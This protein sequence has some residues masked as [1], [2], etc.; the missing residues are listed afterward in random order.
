MENQ[1][2]PYFFPHCILAPV[3]PKQCTKIDKIRADFHSDN[4]F[5]NIPYIKKYEKLEI[6]LW[7]TLK[8]YGL[9]PIFARDQKII[10]IRLCRIC[11]MILSSNYCLTDLSEKRLNVAMEFGIAMAAGRITALMFHNRHDI[12]LELSD[13][14]F[15]DPIG[16]NSDPEKLIISLAKWV[17]DNLKPNTKIDNALII[18]M[19]RNIYN[20][21]VKDFSYEKISLFYNEMSILLKNLEIL[22]KEEIEKI[23]NKRKDSLL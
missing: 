3:L 13:G 9:N 22:E 18:G 6:A 17:E 19:Y 4:V 14:K 20:Q 11:R 16:H 23:R 7:L 21:F 1:A 5:V 12:D 10:E 8:S 2:T 15:V